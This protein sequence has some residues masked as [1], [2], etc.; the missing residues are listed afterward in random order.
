LPPVRVLPDLVRQTLVNLILN[1]ADALGGR[2]V[3]ELRAAETAI[4][5]PDLVLAPARA[6]GFVGVSIKDFGP[7]I[8]PEVLPR[9]F[10]PF[11][12][13]KAFSTRR[14]TGLGLTMVYEIARETGLGLRVESVPGH[15]STFTLFLPVAEPAAPGSPLTPAAGR[16]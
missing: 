14:G 3:I 4:L 10:E 5:P 12:T 11:F 6:P 13:T 8:A 1:A 7:G 2:G 15:G 9:I 16:S